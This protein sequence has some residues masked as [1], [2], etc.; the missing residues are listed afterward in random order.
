MRPNE[1]KHSSTEVYR[2][3]LKFRGTQRRLPQALIIGVRKCGTRALLE[4]L[5][6]HPYVLKNGAE[7][8]FFD[9]DDR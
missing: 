5:N 6:M 9:D 7:M 2:K 4:M 3:R 8:H 1:H